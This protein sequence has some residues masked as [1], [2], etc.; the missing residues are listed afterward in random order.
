[1]NVWGLFCIPVKTFMYS[2]VQ[3]RAAKPVK[4]VE[5]MSYEEKSNELGLFSMW[6]RMLEW[7]HTALYSYLK[8]K[9]LI[10]HIMNDFLYFER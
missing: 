6:R 10:F 2:Y 3:R 8:E 5:N 1:M 4:G 7:D 9:L